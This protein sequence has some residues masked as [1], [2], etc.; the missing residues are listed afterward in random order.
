MPQVS[1][2]LPIIPNSTSP[3]MQPTLQ[4]G[5][6]YMP[7]FFSHAPTSQHTFPVLYNSP[8]PATATPTE[9]QPVSLY[10][11]YMGNPYNVPSPDVYNLG[12][13]GEVNVENASPANANVECEPVSVTNIDLDL[14]K[15]N[16][17]PSG[18]VVKNN[19]TTNF[20]Q[21]SNYFGNATA[22]SCIPV[23]SEI[24]FG[25]EQCNVSS[26]QGIN[27]PITTESK[28]TTDV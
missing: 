3:I 8:V 20:F 27:I 17:Q 1:T 15:N 19:N 28:T 22:A 4:T 26:I 24:L 18:A 13:K 10:A 25:V 2:A 9:V 11:E 5:M 21:S 14:N 16:S 23:G 6:P 7:N 12:G